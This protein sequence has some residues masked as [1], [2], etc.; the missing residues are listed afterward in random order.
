M[1]EGLEFLRANGGSRIRQYEPQPV[2]LDN[3]LMDAEDA[4]QYTG[5]G[6]EQSADEW[7]KIDV[8]QT[9]V[10]EDWLWKPRR[11]VDGK[12]VGRV[13]TC[14]FSAER[15]PVPVYLSQIGAVEMRNEKG[16]LRRTGE[17][18]ETVV[19]LMA[20]LFPWDEVE[21]FAAALQEEGYRML[22]AEKPQP[23]DGTEAHYSYDFERMRKTTHNRSNDEMLRLEK[24]IIASRCNVPTVVDGRLE[25]RASAISKAKVP[26]V[27]VIKSTRRI[28]F[29]L[30]AGRHF[31]NFARASEHLLFF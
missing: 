5:L 19:A 25:P 12:H 31:M 8:S 11:F 14:L 28:I 18:V 26:T 23:K 22:I 1:R 6:F 21:S 24:Q 7:R 10:S 13:A 20:H 2:L 27:G 29:T 3:G 16:C 9:I 15:Y 30:A 4:T 17:T